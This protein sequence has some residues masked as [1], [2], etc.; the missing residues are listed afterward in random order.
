MSTYIPDAVRLSQPM[1]Q[2][3]LWHQKLFYYHSELG[4]RYMK[5]LPTAY[6]STVF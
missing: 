4:W 2:F 5:G 6:D 1:G 3:Q